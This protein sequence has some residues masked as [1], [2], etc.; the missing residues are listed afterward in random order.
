MLIAIAI[1]FDHQRHI[2]DLEYLTGSPAVMTS[3]AGH[4]GL[5]SEVSLQSAGLPAATEVLSTPAT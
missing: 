4:V 5:P 2:A 1:A 3:L